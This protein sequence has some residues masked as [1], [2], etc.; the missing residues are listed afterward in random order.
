[1]INLENKQTVIP[2][3]E[4]A[5]K[6]DAQHVLGILNYAD[7]DLGI[8]LLD[9]KEMQR[10]NKE[11]RDKDKPTDVLSFAYHPALK[12]GERIAPQTEDDKNLGDIMLCPEYIKNDLPNWNQ[13]FEH[14]MRILLVHAICHLLGHDHEEDADY[15]IMQKLEDSLLEKLER[16]HECSPG[17]CDQ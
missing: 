8:W 11:F 14:R 3:H 15:E 10:Y 7:Y 9:P 5:I 2:I 17:N 1:M 13:S 16:G 4:T 6:K 12:A